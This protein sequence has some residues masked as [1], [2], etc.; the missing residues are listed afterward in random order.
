[1]FKWITP[2]LAAALMA[3]PAQAQEELQITDI[4]KGS[5]EEANVGETVVVHYTGWLMDGTKFDSSLDRGTPFSFT[6]GERRVIPG[7]EQGVEGM[8]VGGKRELIIPPEL[9]Y[10]ARGAG[11]VIPPDATLKFE[12]EL[13]EVKAK[14]FSDIGNEALKDKLAAGVPVIDIR[15]PDEWRQTG[16]VPG[17]HLVTFFDQS[18]APNPQF[19]AELQKIISSA[20]DEIILICRTGQRS[21][22]LSQYLSD[23]AGFTN[24]MN[25]EK[26]I[27]DWIADDHE[28]ET[29]SIPDGCWLC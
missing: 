27:V 6:L 2:L 12:I 17:S 25:V 14:K 4:E 11:D 23:K 21:A 10:G 5:G 26:G 24:V 20:S 22:A 15:R 1:M 16:V 29:A 9:G 19:G 8:Q 7:W 13:L 3:F 28:V 18:G